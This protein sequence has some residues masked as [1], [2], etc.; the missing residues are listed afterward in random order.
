MELNLD[1]LLADS[2]IPTLVTH[3]I[4]EY[5][6][7]STHTDNDIA[8]PE[9]RLDPEVWRRAH[10]R[11]VAEGHAQGQRKA[12]LDLASKLLPEHYDVLKGIDDLST[13]QSQLDELLAEHIRS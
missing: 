12:L 6:E 9:R 13:L 10:A 7:M 2:R 1:G 8:F 11:G 3:R 5:I 4:V